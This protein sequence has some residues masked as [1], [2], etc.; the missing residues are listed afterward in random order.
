[1]PQPSPSTQCLCMC[2]WHMDASRLT[3]LHFHYLPGLTHLP[4]SY[5]ESQRHSW[6][7]RLWHSNSAVESEK[8]SAVISEQQA[9]TC[10]VGSL[11]QCRKVKTAAL[12]PILH[13]SGAEVSLWYSETE[14]LQPLL[15][16]GT[17]RGVALP[18]LCRLFLLCTALK[19]EQ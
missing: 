16:R 5:L 17:R 7:L 4:S 13:N 9:A 18:H 8:S 19:A 11:K 15:A 12:W 3:V 2:A 10:E 14:N 6:G 1:M